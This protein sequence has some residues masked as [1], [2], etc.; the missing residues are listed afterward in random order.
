MIAN[1]E[2]SG[3]NNAVVARKNSGV[4]APADLKGKRIG[5]TPG[6]TSDFF[7]DS[8]LTVH[9][10]TRHAIQAVAMKPEEMLDAIENKKVDAVCTWN[11]PLAQ[12]KKRL[13]NNGVVFSDRTIYTETYN[14]AA[15]QE[16]V[17]KNP[18]TVKRFL[19]AIIKAE[20][21]TAKHTEEAQAIMSASSKI[22]IDLVRE[23]WKAFNYQVV[24]DQRLV[25]TLED[26][27]QWA[28]KN[29]LTDQ[30]VMPDYRKFIH[31]DSLKAVKPEAIR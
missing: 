18:E 14:V 9:G 26:E 21:F 19:R 17:Q 24:L 23:A 5:F 29:K 1:V 8:L 27:T 4:L 16:F 12:I 15:Q 20:N 13:G 7:L 30:T 25:I 11:Y 6:T 31:F 22:D 2:A 3:M 28:M 10:I